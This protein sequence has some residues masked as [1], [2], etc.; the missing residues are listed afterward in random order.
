MSPIVG[1][2]LRPLERG[3][4]RSRVPSALEPSRAP[5]PPRARARSRLP[6]NARRLRS[7][8]ERTPHRAAP[9]RDPVSRRPRGESP[10]PG[11]RASAEPAA[12]RRP[13]P[14]GSRGSLPAGPTGGCRCPGRRAACAPAAV[15]WRRVLAVGGVRRPGA[16]PGAGAGVRRGDGGGHTSPLCGG[17]VK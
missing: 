10:G 6:L 17:D 3:Q 12:R 11:R 8:A 1:R 15:L 16:S 14:C 7:R 5:L 4:A 9:L 2:Q 13:G